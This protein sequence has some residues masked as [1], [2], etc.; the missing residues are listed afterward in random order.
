MFSFVRPTPSSIHRRL[1]KARDLPGSYGI[2]LNTQCGPEE[3]HV[4]RGYVR[5]HIRTEIGHGAAAFEAA[6]EAFR[7][8]QHFD[9]GWVRV[10]NPEA[11]IVPE[12]ILAV[13]VHSLG[14]WSLNFSRILYVIDEPDR[15]GFGYGTTSLHVERG[16]ERFLLEFYP[17][18]G[19]VAYDL[20]AVSQPANWLAWL[21]YPYT[22]SQQHRFARDSH[23]RMKQALSVDA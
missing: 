8:W 12:E 19:V 16:E 4:P 9:L 20:L 11:Q 22:R 1:E 7:N 13:E 3:L 10:A 2:A 5:D 21:G 14:L 17:V 23:Q 6:K 15:F 18:S